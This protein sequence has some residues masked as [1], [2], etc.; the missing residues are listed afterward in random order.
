MRARRSGSSN[1]RVLKMGYEIFSKGLRWVVNN[2][3]HV[4]F[5]HDIWVGNYTLR[6]QIQGPLPL[7]KDSFLICDVI[8]GLSLWDFSKILVNLPTS[9]RES[10][11]AINVCSI[12]LHEDKLV[13]DSPV[14][15][16]VLRRLTF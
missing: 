5:W 11:K 10:I 7:H 13:W 16:S 14:V 8:E 3:H 15:N 6:E 12:S 4:S 9:A 2:G 1:W